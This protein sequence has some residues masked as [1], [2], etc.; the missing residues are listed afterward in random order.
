[1]GADAVVTREVQ[2]S[3]ASGPLMAHLSW[4]D[5]CDG[6]V[7]FAHGSGSSR[8][9]PRN[10]FVA[11]RLQAAGLATLL[12][13]LLTPREAKDDEVS[14]RWRF[15]LSLLADRL[16]GTVDWLIQ[17]GMGNGPGPAAVPVGLFGASTG[18]AAALL[19]A[20]A[21]PQAIRALVCRGGRPD[22]APTALP[23]VRC[24]TLFIV[25]GADPE[26]LAL[27]QQALATL[28]APRQLAVVPGASHLFV[29]T[30][31]LEQVGALAQE[32]FHEHLPSPPSR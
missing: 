24:P 12:I 31:A 22:L 28:T 18:A 32:W 19:T 15:D 8:F 23:R 30:G 16:T 17:H 29:E 10:H 14:H 7:V 26:V 25:G 20:A 1:M 13:D 27:N 21:R 9:S 2:V 5:P 6:V 3:T 11:E 4:P